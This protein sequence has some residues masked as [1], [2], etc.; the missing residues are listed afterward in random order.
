LRKGG[1]CRINLLSGFRYLNLN[2]GLAITDITDTT[3]GNHFFDTDQ[4]STRNQFY[5]GQIGVR[6]FF[7]RRRLNLE[8]DGKVAMG[9]NRQSVEI[10]GASS[11]NL[12]SPLNSRAG[13]LA[14]ITNIGLYHR[15]EFTVVPEVKAQLTY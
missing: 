8:I 4:F 15:Q 2:E 9:S 14:L 7:G 1:Y 5:G 12:N 11:N 13:I 3:S 10:N 6:T